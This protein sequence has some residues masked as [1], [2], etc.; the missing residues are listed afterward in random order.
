VEHTDRFPA[1]SPWCVRNGKAAGISTSRFGFPGGAKRM[2]LVC[3]VTL[4]GCAR[5]QVRVRPVDTFW[6]VGF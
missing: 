2:M 1:R 4:T 6:I 5:R 3:V